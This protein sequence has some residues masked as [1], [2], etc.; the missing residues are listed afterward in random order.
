MRARI[1]NVKPDIFHDEELW[2]L[3]EATQLPIYQGFQ[4][5]WC[6][7]D[8]EGRF[9]W[10]PMALQSLILPYWRGDFEAVLD[11]LASVGMVVKYTV[12]GRAYGWVRTLKRHQKTNAREPESTLPAPPESAAHCNDAAPIVHDAAAH[13]QSAAPSVHDAAAHCE[14]D[15]DET[16]LHRSARAERRGIGD[17]IGIGIGIGIGD[18]VGVG[19]D[20]ER[21]AAAAAPLKPAKRSKA[22]TP[23]PDDLA[24]NAAERSLATELRV[25]LAVEFPKFLDHH[26]AHGSLMADWQSA[27]R[28]WIRNAHEWGRT[29]NG[30][31]NRN[32][33]NRLQGRNSDAIEYARELGSGGEAT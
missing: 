22:R 7:A 16:P 18:G 25:N 27:L 17:G 23:L 29:G 8:K 12:D 30:T 21:P 10:R 31:G 1:R 20:A 3:G 26:R 9:E 33:G 2:A 32:G 5:L 11:A 24:P 28:K 4:G 19:V 15:D 13:V 14:D 6:Y